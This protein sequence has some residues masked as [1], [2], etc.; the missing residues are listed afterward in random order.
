MKAYLQVKGIDGECTE[1]DHQKWINVTGFHHGLSQRMFGN[2][3]GRPQHGSGQADMR[4]FVVTKELDASSPNLNFYCAQNKPVA[5]VTLHVIT[6]A[7]EKNHKTLVIQLKDAVISSVQL[8][9]TADGKAALPEETVSF[10]FSKISWEY[11]PLTEKVGGGGSVKTEFH[12][13]ENS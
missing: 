8:S 9:G 4:D 7:N 2:A 10:R 13:K 6:K 1:K 11:I 3:Q 12:L 5:D